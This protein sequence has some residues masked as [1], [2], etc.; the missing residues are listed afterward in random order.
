M[1]KWMLYI[2]VFLG[3]INLHGDRPTATKWVITS[4]CSLRVDGSTNVN[5]FSCAITGYNKPDTILVTRGNSSIQ[6]D[7]DIQLDVPR[8][9]CHN[10]VMT[11]D[12][13]KTLKAKQFPNLVIRFIS[14]DKYP[15]QATSETI[16]KGIVVIELAGVSRQFE[17][18]YKIASVD[19]NNITLAGFQKLNFSDFN[20]A[21]PKKLGGMIKT[22]DQLNV[23]FNLNIKVVV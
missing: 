13:R 9:D 17:I 6:L 14:I 4:G 18:N 16:T 11:A 8:F 7:G 19:Q 23:L 3:A 12:L 5:S 10:A 1:S 15:C 21:P 20:I 22:N 2:L